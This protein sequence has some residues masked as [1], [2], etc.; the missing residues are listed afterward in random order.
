[1]IA[2][3][4][5]T[6]ISRPHDSFVARWPEPWSTLDVR[7]GSDPRSHFTSERKSYPQDNPV[8]QI[9]TPRPPRQFR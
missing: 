5:V 4:I 2:F 1:M 3:L 7:S 9:P 8:G 6:L